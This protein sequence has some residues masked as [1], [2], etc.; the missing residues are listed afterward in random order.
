VNLRS[1]G[2][3]SDPADPP[4]PLGAYARGRGERALRAAWFRREG[5][6]AWTARRLGPHMPGPE[7]AKLAALNSLAAAP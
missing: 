3:G 2:V 1:A 4:G 5:R 6:P 7:A